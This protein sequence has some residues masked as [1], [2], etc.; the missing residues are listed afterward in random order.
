MASVSSSLLA[1]KSLTIQPQNQQLL[2]FK[3][4]AQ[5]RIIP[6][7][8]SSLTVRAAKLP[9]GVELPKVQ[10]KFVAPFLGFT[11]TAEI[12]NSRACMIGLIGTFIVE[13]ILNKGIL[14]VIGVD[15]GK[16]LDLPL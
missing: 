5:I 4:S 3:N 8:P 15:V 12:W 1:T 10:P 16:G 2:L 13:L 7:K 9:P 14:Q 11:R 6:K